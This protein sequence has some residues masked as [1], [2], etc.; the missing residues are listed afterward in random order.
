MIDDL[1]P[2]NTHPK[3][4]A[5]AEQASVDTES[6]RCSDFQGGELEVTKP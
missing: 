4:S 6:P 3:P 5:I 1:N 2:I